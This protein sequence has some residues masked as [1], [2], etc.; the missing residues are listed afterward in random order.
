MK[1]R[2]QSVRSCACAVITVGISVTRFGDFLHFGQQ[3]FFPNRTHCSAIFV[4]V[5]KSFI[6]LVNSFL[7]NF[8]R[9]HTGWYQQIF[10]AH[11]FSLA[12]SMSVYF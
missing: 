3:L 10:K 6:F 4:K 12:N 1:T 2:G 11:I 5:S 8:Y 9:H 7:G